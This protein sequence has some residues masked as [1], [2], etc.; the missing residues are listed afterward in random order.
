MAILLASMGTF[1]QRDMNLLQSVQNRFVKRVAWRCNV[2]RASLVLP[3]V[4]ELQQKNDFRMFRRLQR[5]DSFIKY[6][7]VRQ[8]NLRSRVF[9]NPPE[10][11]TLDIVNNSFA[12]RMARRIHHDPRS[13]VSPS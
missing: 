9:V 2:H 10:I 4:A 11:A 5:T 7:D 1:Y 3:S 13:V 12:W 6:F 8:N